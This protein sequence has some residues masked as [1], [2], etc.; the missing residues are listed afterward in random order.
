MLKIPKSI[1]PPKL[2]NLHHG[3]IIIIILS[4]N[5]DELKILQPLAFLDDSF[6]VIDRGFCLTAH[7]PPSC[8]SSQFLLAIGRILICPFTSRNVVLFSL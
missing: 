7:K 5:P 4:R 8:P 2:V 3:I 6:Y 1:P